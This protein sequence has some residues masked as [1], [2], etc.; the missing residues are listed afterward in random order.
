MTIA[1]FIS[2]LW[3]GADRRAHPRR[4]DPAITLVVDGRRIETV[5]WSLGG[6]N[7]VATE[8]GAGP[9][10]PRDTITGTLRLARVP[11]GQ[12]VAE[13]ARLTDDGELGLRWLEISTAT[14]AAMSAKYS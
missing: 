1:R 7:L 6:C 9:F 8:V 5:D 12:F 14:F 11:D 3:T 2:N 4:R 13:I 10:R